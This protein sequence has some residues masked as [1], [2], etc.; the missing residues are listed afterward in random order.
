MKKLHG[1]KFA[2]SGKKV[3]PLEIVIDDDSDLDSSVDE[4]KEKEEADAE[5]I[6]TEENPAQEDTFKMEEKEDPVS[7]NSIESVLERTRRVHNQARPQED[8]PARQER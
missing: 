4:E 8:R 6:Q 5:S 7:F 2:L 1:D 3:D